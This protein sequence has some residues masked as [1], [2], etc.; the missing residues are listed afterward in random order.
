MFLQDK[1]SLQVPPLF[2]DLVPMYSNE[3][4][5]VIESAVVRFAIVASEHL[6]VVA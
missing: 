2:S 4:G 3:T 1:D 6:I 5:L